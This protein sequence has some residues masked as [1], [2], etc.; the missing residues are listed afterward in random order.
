MLRKT[1]TITFSLHPE[2]ALKVE[3]IKRHE[4]RT[5]SELLRE[6]LRLY[7][8]TRQA[9]MVGN[10]TSRRS[11]KQIVRCLKHIVIMENQM[12]LQ[13]SW[14]NELLESLLKADQ[15]TDVHTWFPYR[16]SRLTPY[17]YTEFAK[18]LHH[19][20]IALRG[21]GISPEQAS[22]HLTHVTHFR[23]ELDN[24]LAYWSH[25][26]LKMSRLE[27]STVCNY[28]VELLSTTCRDDIFSKNG[29]LLLIQ[30]ENLAHIERST[31]WTIPTTLLAKEVG[32]L[33]VSLNTLAY[34]LYTDVWANAVGDM[35]HGP[36][37]LSDGRRLVIRDYVDLAPVELW[38][39]CADWGIKKVRI[40]TCYRPGV[41]LEIDFYG[42]LNSKSSL[43]D[44]LS[45]FAVLLGNYQLE[46]TSIN[47]LIVSIANKAIEQNRT[48]RSLDYEELK[49]IFLE[50]HCYTERDLFQLAGIDWR[51]TQSMYDMVTDKELLPGAEDW[52]DDRELYMKALDAVLNP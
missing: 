25:G 35:Y 3:Q 36:Y 37:T 46:R 42:S 7:M 26:D 23:D 21:S 15:T 4:D 44:G 20:C 30:P 14:A 13:E 51:P 34:G 32:K 8:R 6:A 40:L 5:M 10:S 17:Y 27:L 9:D 52:G 39:H 47:E 12:P 1:K 33:V 43:I 16:D 24:L 48:I 45:G 19:A 28:I 50:A 38:S 11:G 2:M 29:R 41:D 18:R 31:E 49:R 22:M